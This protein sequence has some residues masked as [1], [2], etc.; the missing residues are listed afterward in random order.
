[1][2][3][4][5]SQG[6]V[7]SAQK[8]LVYG[9]EGIG[10][11]TF[12]SQFPNPVFIDTEGS[13]GNM[14][15]RRLPAPT[16]WQMLMQE[17]Q[18]VRDTPGLCKTLVIDTI[19]WAE[20]LCVREVCSSHQ[21]SSIEEFG[22][23]AGYTYAYEE[24]GKLLNLLSDVIDKGINVCLLAHSMI[25]KFEQP[26]EEAAY[27][28]YQLKLIDTPKKSIANMVKEWAD[29]VLFANYK[30]IVE[31]VGEG[32]KAKGKARGN[33]RVMYAQHHACWDAKNRWGLPAELPFDYQEIAPY[34]TQATCANSAPV[35]QV[36]QTEPQHQVD[37][38]PT[39][40]PEQAQPQQMA[41]G[42]PE[43][44]SAQSGLPDF[45]AP[46]ESLMQADGVTIDDVR[47]VAADHGHFTLDT[48]PENYP[49]EYITGFLVPSWPQ[50][51]E[52][53]KENREPVPF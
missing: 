35:Q 28:R 4:D 33:K 51:L 14:D 23:G 24:F 44:S 42:T 49:P 39:L 21:K 8:V 32:I 13:T 22:Y 40:M 1:M 10:K 25:R 3:F 36:A 27:D 48:P 46:V 31:I 53:I 50:V 52:V 18:Y 9:V 17:V 12:A 47:K 34:I 16:S 6:V 29:V 43:A 7:A 41:Q 19:D 37:Q 45:W 26:D 11:S 5:I 30:T 2:Q 38:A 20:R 15:V